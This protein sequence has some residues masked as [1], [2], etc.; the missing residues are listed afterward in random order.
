MGRVPSTVPTVMEM[1]GWTP[2]PREPPEAAAI[3]AGP[4]SFSRTAWIPP[5]KACFLSGLE[6]PSGMTLGARTVP[7]L[8]LQ[9]IVLWSLTSALHIRPAAGAEERLR[10]PG[11]RK[12]RVLL[13]TK[14]QGSQA[15]GK[16]KAPPEA[17]TGAAAA[18]LFP[19]TFHGAPRY[20]PSTG[21]NKRNKEAR[22]PW[23]RLPQ[24][25]AGTA[26]RPVGFS[27]GWRGRR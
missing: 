10:R 27:E 18:A 2:S 5:F 20:K 21:A 17:P 7:S 6:E 14:A 24:V 1:Q 16:T 13:E 23:G 26:R 22:E 9:K 3:T 15:T 11:S 8:I 12:P 4:V 19:R 25:R